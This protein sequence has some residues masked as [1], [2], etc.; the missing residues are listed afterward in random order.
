MAFSMTRPAAQAPRS[1]K[2]AAPVATA[3]AG[4]ALPAR[5]RSVA[6]STPAIAAPTAPTAPNHNVDLVSL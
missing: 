3:R 5:R 1:A 6:V 4:P 2:A